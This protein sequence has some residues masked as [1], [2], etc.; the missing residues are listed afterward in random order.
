MLMPWSELFGFLDGGFRE[1]IETDFE[2]IRYG[3]VGMAVALAIVV[4]IVLTLTLIRLT[5]TRKR[6]DRQHSGHVIAMQHRKR[7]W[8]RALHTAPKTLLAGA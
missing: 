5:A 7:L 4:G 3:D 2:Q 8:I 6:H 1:L